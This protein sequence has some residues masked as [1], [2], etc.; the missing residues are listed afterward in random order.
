MARPTNR[1]EGVGAV[2]EGEGGLEITVVGRRPGRGQEARG[3]RQQ[4][5]IPP[6]L[7]HLDA[8]H[9]IRQGTAF[10]TVTYIHIQACVAPSV[11]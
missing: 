5:C 3:P 8:G 2:P 11:N 7:H 4:S 10:M 6:A 9:K 1:C